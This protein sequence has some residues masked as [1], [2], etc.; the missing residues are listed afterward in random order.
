MSYLTCLVAAGLVRAA[1][2]WESMAEPA[3]KIEPTLEEVVVSARRRTENLQEV[4]AAVT[5]LSGTTLQQIAASDV[6]EIQGHV[7]NLTIL[8]GRNQ[9]STLAAY[10]RGVGQADPLWGVDSG[11]GLYFD[12]V[13]IARPQ[14]ALLDVFDVDRIEVLR[15][16]QGT[17]YGKNSIAGAIRYLSR[18][19]SDRPEASLSVT[20]GEHQTREIRAAI[21]GPLAP[22]LRGKLAGASL[23][24][25]GY[26]SN[27]RTGDRLSDRNGTAGRALLEW[28][29]NDAWIV[30]IASDQSRDRAGPKGYQRLAENPLC[31]LFT[32]SRCAPL[33]GRWDSE[34]GLTP[35]NRSDAKGYALTTTWTSA[36]W[37]LRSITS[38]RTTATDNNIDFDTVEAPILDITASNSSRQLSAEVQLEYRGPGNSDVI[39]GGYFFDGAAGGFFAPVGF[40]GLFNV[41]NESTVETES[42]AVFGDATLPLS[43]RITLDAGLRLNRENKA[44]RIFNRSF[45]DSEFTLPR[46]VLADVDDEVTFDS[47]MPR[48]ALIY[49]ASVNHMTF[50]SAS[51]GVRSGGFNIR[52]NN[53]GI[54]E[55]SE[56]FGDETLD[57]IE[58]GLRSMLW[59][60]RLR[61]NATLFHGRYRDVQV[62]VFDSADIDGDGNPDL[63][64]TNFTNIADASTEGVEIEFQW[65][66]TAWLSLTGNVNWL[67]AAPDAPVDLDE[68]GILDSQV[69][70]NAPR[71]TGGLFASAEWPLATG[72]LKASLG[73]NYRD[74]SVLTENGGPLARTVTQ[75]AMWLWDGSV[76]WESRSGKWLVA[77]NGKNLRDERYLTS[78]Y[79]VDTLGIL[80]G[81]NGPPRTL[82]AT[83]R[84]SFF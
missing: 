33:P 60:S 8:P 53:P 51:R 44:A 55:L 77:I 66:A 49:R 70:T 16:P 41:V 63:G 9:S 3:P 28:R 38:Y 17:L 59:D 73:V 61:L 72:T 25:N 14:S 62:N 82:T 56:P 64:F 12:D 84:Y 2:E 37:V 76:M 45:F 65:A 80:L 19:P 10:I 15:G 52:A 7:P 21:S 40:G 54:P 32:G 20:A 35:G 42:F 11:V 74:P 30:A 83:V 79:D 27:L 5:A 23:E 36:P 26:G 57:L 50:L 1:L 47:M 81:S 24:H 22:G 69:I 58:A 4:S 78:A 68:D 75:P 46:N 13:Y 67:D 31:P 43:E 71:L 48:L 6:S 39:L 18:R 29:P 34:A